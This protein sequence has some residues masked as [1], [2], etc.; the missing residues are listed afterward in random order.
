MKSSHH[1]ISIYESGETMRETLAYDVDEEVVLLKTKFLLLYRK[2]SV[3][4]PMMVR[5]ELTEFGY[6]QFRSG[7]MIDRTK[8]LD[9]LAFN[10]QQLRNRYNTHLEERKRIEN[11]AAP[12]QSAQ[13]IESFIQT[14]VEPLDRS[15]H[16]NNLFRKRRPIK[17]PKMCH[18]CCCCCV[19]CIR[20]CES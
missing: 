15:N 8:Q 16:T 14:N 17:F 11:A 18:A 12:N 4:K 5:L 9:K 1:S 2:C 19:A 10:I 7:M 13:N 20:C 3:D 6:E